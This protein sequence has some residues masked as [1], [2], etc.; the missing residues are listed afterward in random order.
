MAFQPSRRRTL[1]ANAGLALSHRLAVLSHIG[2]LCG[3]AE[4][5]QTVSH[6]RLTRMLQSDWSGHTLLDV[7]CRTLFAW[8]R[9]FLIIDDTVLAKPFATAIESLAWVYSSQERKPVYGLSLVLLVWTNGVLRVPLGIRLWH[10]GG[11][12]K[13]RLGRGVSSAMRATDC[14]VAPPTSSSTRGIRQEPC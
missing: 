9:G 10:R 11:S 1:H 5:L 3:L 8:E 2:H 14:A 13:V 12:L 7:V 4:A 6:D